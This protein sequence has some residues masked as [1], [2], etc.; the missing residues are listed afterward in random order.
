[1]SSAIDAIHQKAAQASAPAQQQQDE[2]PAPAT[3]QPGDDTT[4][5]SALSAEDSAAAEKTVNLRKDYSR[6]QE[7][8]THL[9]DN[10]G[11]HRAF[12]IPYVDG[13]E[14]AEHIANV[15]AVAAQNGGLTANLITSH[16][17]SGGKGFGSGDGVTVGFNAEKLRMTVIPKGNKNAEDSISAA[18]KLIRDVAFLVGDEDQSV[19][20][21]RGQM[22]LFAKAQGAGMTCFDLM[23]ALTNIVHGPLQNVAR[24]ANSARHG[25]HAMPRRT[26]HKEA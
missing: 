17:H 9:A 4:S 15:G 6:L 24:T 8:L 2:T 13:G 21:A 11:V 26:G 7:H 16:H 14:M 3:A 1:M 12:T 22:G 5:T 25:G 20:Q 18:N 23:V 19:K 10:T